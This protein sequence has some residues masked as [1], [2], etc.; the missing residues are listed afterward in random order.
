MK[1]KNPQGEVVDADEIEIV[2]EEE[3]WNRYELADGTVVKVKPVVV[4]IVRLRDTYSQ[5]GSPV[6]LVESKNVIGSDS[7]DELKNLS[8]TEEV[9]DNGS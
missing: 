7:P 9:E 2:S 4:K 5:D 1:A 8:D 6:Y 3:Y